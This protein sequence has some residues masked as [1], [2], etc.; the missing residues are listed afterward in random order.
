MTPANF[1]ESNRTLTKPRDMTDEQ[2]TS[3]PVWTDGEHCLSC[4]QGTWLERL[5]FLFTGK[6]WLWVH[7][8]ET[9]PPVAVGTQYPFQP[10]A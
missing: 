1:E 7:S 6:L 8:G 4:W 5:Q 9:Q 10:P 2:C 3:L